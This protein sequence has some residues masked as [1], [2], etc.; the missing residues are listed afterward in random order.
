[1]AI[2][3]ISQYDTFFHIKLFLSQTILYD[4]AQVE[5]VHRVHCLVTPDKSQTPVSLLEVEHVNIDFGSCFN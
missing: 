2:E 3:V 1:M 5:G 4:T